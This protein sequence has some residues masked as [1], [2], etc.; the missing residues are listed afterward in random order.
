[1]EPPDLL[2]FSLVL[3]QICRFGMGRGAGPREGRVDIR[4]L[5]YFVRVV[6]LG[7]FSRAAAFLHIAQSALSRQI[8]GLEIELKER[9]LVRNG[10][11]V[12]PTEAGERLMGHARSIIELYDR[13]YEDMENARL[14][15]TGS[16]AIGMPGSL[17]GVISTALIRKL[18]AELPDAKV[19]VLT[20]RSTQLQE[21]LVSGRIDMAVVFDAPNN[22]MLEVHD[23]FVERLHLYER[24]PEGETETLGPPVPL[25]EIADTPLIITS[26]PNRIREFLEAALA[27]EGRKLLVECELDALETTF[28][29]LRDGVGKSV[30]TLRSLR[31]VPSAGGLRV[32]RIVEP[33]LVLKL[34]IVL[35]TRRLN[36]RLHEAAFRILRDLCMDLLAHRDGVPPAAVEALPP[37]RPEPEGARLP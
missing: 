31:T 2:Q 26:R 21:W 19:H 34:Q 11:G 20:G 23:L 27:R 28:D 6:E 17:S 5:T 4:Q 3:Y 30:A 36:N 33:E 16:V 15:R 24:M 32:R 18:H 8:N 22:S 37:P 12:T 14:G 35:R 1:M 13:A 29:L 25:A 7:S 9:L 10:R